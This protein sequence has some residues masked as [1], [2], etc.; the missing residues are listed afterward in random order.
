MSKEQF[1]QDQTENIEGAER[2]YQ[3]E[4]FDIF[5]VD[6]Y[7]GGKHLA[8]GTEWDAY[9]FEDEFEYSVSLNTLFYILID[10]L[11][12]DVSMKKVEFAISRGDD[13]KVYCYTAINAED[14]LL[15]NSLLQEH[16]GKEY[17]DTLRSIE[18]DGNNRPKPT[19]YNK[20][21]CKGCHLQFNIFLQNKSVKGIA[22]LNDK[23]GSTALHVEA[24]IDEHGKNVLE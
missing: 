20:E 24:L 21:F 11:S 5:R 3:S 22:P 15:T 6:S 19:N 2:I 10:K 16:L 9:A 7:N 8:K 14:K 17:N 4:R 23:F 12:L 18:V 1:K 13:N